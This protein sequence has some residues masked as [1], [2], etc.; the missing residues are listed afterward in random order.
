M[1]DLCVILCGVIL[2]KIKLGSQF[3]PE[4]QGIFLGEKFSINFC[5][6][7]D[8]NISQ[9]HIN[10][11]LKDINFCSEEN[12]PQYGLHPITFIEWEIWHLS[13]K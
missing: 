2:K 10:Y 4:E 12:S 9:E 7:M 13:W 5:I 6:S 8:L 3:P 1:M 11:A